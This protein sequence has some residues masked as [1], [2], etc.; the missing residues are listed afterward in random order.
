[1]LNDL[2]SDTISRTSRGFV[3]RRTAK[4]ITPGATQIEAVDQE[5][6]ILAGFRLASTAH[7]AIAVGFLVDAEHAAAVAEVLIADHHRPA[8]VWLHHQRFLCN[9]RRVD[10]RSLFARNE[11]GD[12]I[13]QNRVARGGNVLSKIELPG[14]GS[15]GSVKPLPRAVARILQ[16]GI[17]G[18]A[19]GPRTA[20][21]RLGRQLRL[22]CRPSIRSVEVVPSAVE[23]A[24]LRR[25]WGRTRRS[26]R[27]RPCIRKSNPGRQNR[28]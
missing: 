6:S 13:I 14:F 15:L 19:I 24:P 28:R 16:T 21:H 22:P 11:M 10:C 12:A 20:L 7:L 2:D 8:T 25:G 3:Q 17:R 4:I 9:D 5:K 26:P 1:M 18:T 27:R 23:R